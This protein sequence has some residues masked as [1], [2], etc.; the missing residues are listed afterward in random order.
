M[1]FTEQ[2]FHGAILSQNLC[3][4][5]PKDSKFQKSEYEV[6]QIGPKDP[7]SKNFSLLVSKGDE[8]ASTQI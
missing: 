1:K 7:G 6:H 3:G 4:R 5:Y 2:N 8:P